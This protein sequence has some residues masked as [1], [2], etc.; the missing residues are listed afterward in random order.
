MRNI[1]YNK[2]PDIEIYMRDSERAGFCRVKVSD[3]FQF[4]YHLIVRPHINYHGVSMQFFADFDDPPISK[5]Q[6]SYYIALAKKG[7]EI[8]D[9]NV[10]EINRRIGNHQHGK[11]VYSMVPYQL[12]QDFQFWLEFQEAEDKK[13]W[14]NAILLTP[15]TSDF[16]KALAKE[17]LSGLEN[18]T[19]TTKE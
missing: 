3:L 18:K 4:D 17:Y 12:L 19:V 10:I 5:W 6:D 7:G 8:V 1:E 13:A 16:Q 11:F 15:E 9:I 2:A 14:S